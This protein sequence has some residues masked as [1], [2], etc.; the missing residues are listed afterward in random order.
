MIVALSRSSKKE[1]VSPA[2]LLLFSSDITYKGPDKQCLC[3]GSD[4]CFS[5]SNSTTAP[6]SS[7]PYTS[8]FTDS[9]TPTFSTDTSSSFT[10]TPSSSSSFYTFSSVGPSSASSNDT[11]LSSTPQPARAAGAHQLNVGAI[12]GG[13]IG[14]M[15]LLML[16]L[17]LLLYRQRKAHRA[18]PSAE[19]SAARTAVLACADTIMF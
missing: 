17:G 10:L 14:G 19:V 4:Q 9:G 3:K 12:V 1:T 2:P 15:V 16:I 7:T 11:S 13:T 18:P 6:A 8:L 5:G